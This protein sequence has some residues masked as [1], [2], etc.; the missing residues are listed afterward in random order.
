VTA[1][2]IIRGLS[3]TPT[4]GWWR[5]ECRPDRGG[6]GWWIDSDTYGDAWRLERHHVCH[7]AHTWDVPAVVDVQGPPAGFYGPSWEALLVTAP[8]A[9]RQRSRA[10][11]VAS[12]FASGAARTLVGTVSGRRS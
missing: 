5:V 6:C 9:P 2:T 7:P 4:F 3:G 8:R 11:R 1:R 10:V 12:G